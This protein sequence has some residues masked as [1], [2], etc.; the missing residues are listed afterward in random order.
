LIAIVAAMKD[1]VRRLGSLKR[2][3]KGHASLTVTGV[4]KEKALAA[5]ASLCDGGNPP[6][7]VLSIGFS[8]ALSDDLSVGDLVLARRL[9]STDGSPPLTIDLRLFQLAEAAIH[10]NALPYVRRDTLTAGKLVRTRSEREK[11]HREFNA[12][13]VS[14]EDYWICRAAS[15]AGVPFVSVRAISDTTSKELPPYVE[16]IMLQ[17]EARRGMRVIL[18]SLA[19]P[20]RLPTLMSLARAA[21]KAQKSLETFTKTFVDQAIRRESPRPAQR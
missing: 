18:N 3:S 16:E 5:V 2:T 20:H 21:K 11:L 1:E 10:E 17:R 9:L 8:G 7:L 14:L 19:R 4:G 12:Q 13:A 15:Q 6:S